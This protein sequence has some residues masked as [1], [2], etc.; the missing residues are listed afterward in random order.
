[1]PKNN[2]VF[3]KHHFVLVR[4]GGDFLRDLAWSHCPGLPTTTATWR[5]LGPVFHLRGL[6]VHSTDCLTL[7]IP[8]YPGRSISGIQE[9]SLEILGHAGQGSLLE[10]PRDDLQP[11][12]SL[13]DLLEKGLRFVLGVSQFKTPSKH[14]SRSSFFHRWGNWGRE[15]EVSLLRPHRELVVE[16]RLGSRALRPALLLHS[17]LFF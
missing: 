12:F 2:G 17:V 1:M 11:L 14:Q 8:P 16:P 4:P 10:T 3:V 9:V 7:H 13:R 5:S 6:V 15:K